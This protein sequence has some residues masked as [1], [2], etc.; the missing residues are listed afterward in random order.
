M[1]ALLDRHARAD[2]VQSANMMTTLAGRMVGLFFWRAYV[3][4]DAAQK[5]GGCT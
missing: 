1:R 2:G 3:G 4:A 5:G